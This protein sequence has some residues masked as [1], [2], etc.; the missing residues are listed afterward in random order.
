MEFC[1]LLSNTAQKNMKKMADY[2]I[3]TMKAQSF[4]Y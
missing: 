2:L 4:N 3:V 1:M